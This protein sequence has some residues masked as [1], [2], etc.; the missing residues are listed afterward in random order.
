MFKAILIFLSINSS[1]ADET[2]KNYYTYLE[3]NQKAPYSGY[4]LTDESIASIIS[5][6]EKELSM[7]DLYIE[8]EKKRSQIREIEIEENFNR[9]ILIEKNR[10]VQYKKQRNILTGVMGISIVVGCAI[11]IIAI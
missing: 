3:K 2:V 10:S 9:Q 6:H 11:A 4:L 7:K 5:Q 1:F 8:Y